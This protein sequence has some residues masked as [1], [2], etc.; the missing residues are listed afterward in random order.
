[1]FSVKLISICSQMLLHYVQL[2]V[3]AR[4]VRILCQNCK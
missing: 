2:M 4:D 3:W 1:M